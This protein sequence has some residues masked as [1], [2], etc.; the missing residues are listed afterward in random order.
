[1]MKKATA[2]IFLGLVSSF[3]VYSHETKKTNESS[4][5][6]IGLLKDVKSLEE[7]DIEVGLL[8]AIAKIEK[9][10]VQFPSLEE[11]D[12]YIDQLEVYILANKSSDVDKDSVNRYRRLYYFAKYFK[13]YMV[14]DEVY[15]LEPERQVRFFD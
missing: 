5:D 9:E 2:I 10:N 15:C 1:M 8:N 4:Y 6:L 11:I 3:F 14:N 7:K 12:F 13:A